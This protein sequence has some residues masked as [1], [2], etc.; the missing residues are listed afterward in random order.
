MESEKNIEILVKSSSGDPYTVSF[1]IDIN[2]ISAFCSCQAGIY[3]ILCKHI[4]GVIGNDD[5]ILY[6]EK[7]KKLMKKIC[8]HL[9]NT[10]IPLLFS[11]WKES[12]ELLK[13]AQQNVKKSKKYLE[14]AILKK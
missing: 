7:Q 8:T 13:K 3:R 9:Q 5:S 11:E 4:I 1:N 6:D 10:N 2:N 14:K 12:E